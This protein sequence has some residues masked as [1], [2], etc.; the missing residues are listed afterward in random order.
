MVIVLDIPSKWLNPN[1]RIHWRRKCSLTFSHKNKAFWVTRAEL[2]AAGPMPVFEGYTLAFWHKTNRR[3]DD[4]N[5]SA[6]CKA[7]RDGVAQA[8]GVDDSSLRQMGPPAMG[9]D[10]FNPRLEIRLWT[11][12]EVIGLWTGVL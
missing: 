8:L 6:M 12:E 1:E 10:K 3:R 2:P 11:R 7:Y 9:V 4:D 5:C